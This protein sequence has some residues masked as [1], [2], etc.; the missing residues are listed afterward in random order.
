MGLGLGAVSGDYPYYVTKEL[1]L[2]LLAG[3]VAPPFIV[4]ARKLYPQSAR[5]PDAVRYYLCYVAAGFGTGLVVLLANAFYPSTRHWYDL[6]NV[7][8]VFGIMLLMPPLGFIADAVWAQ[9]SERTRTRT[10]FG[11]YVSESIANRVLDAHTVAGLEGETRSATIL[12]ADIRGFTRMLQELGAEQVVQTLN[13]YFTCMIDVI[14]QFDGTVDKFIGDAIVVLYNAPFSQPDANARA[15]ATA[16]AMQNALQG[17]N[18]AR[19][20]DALAAASNRDRD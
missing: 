20:Q 12:I 16:R 7:T 4:L 11:Q 1:I 18:L 3:L 10:I 2:G 9:R 14:G 8:Y 17:L 5:S 15:I 19:A 6:A 13:D